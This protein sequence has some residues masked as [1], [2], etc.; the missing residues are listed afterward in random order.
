MDISISCGKEKFFSEIKKI[1]YC[2]VDVPFA[3]YNEREWILSNEYKD[4]VGKKYQA[5]KDAGLNISQTHLTYYPGHLKTIGDGTY[6]AFE[7][8]MLPLF[9]REIELTSE[10]N[11]PVAVIHL[12][13][14][15]DREKS[16]EG[17]KRLI[18]GLLPILEKNNVV[19]S[20]ENIFGPDLS[21]AYLS[22]AD[23][24]LYYTDFFKN[25]YLGICLDTGHAILRNQNPVEMLKAVQNNLT[26]LHLHTTVPFVDLH[27]VPYMASYLEQIDWVEF[28]DILSKTKY[29]GTFNMEVRAS[30]KMND[31]AISAFYRFAYEVAKGIVN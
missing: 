16:R 15:N 23:D 30:S 29:K 2:G 4:I 14:E 13:F 10:I 6:E 11:C 26:A 28:Y 9:I 25:D 18:T 12:Y 24:L 8:Y 3:V 17:N 22:G 27:A 19:L 31:N 20:I 1:G 7:E 5:A 21:E